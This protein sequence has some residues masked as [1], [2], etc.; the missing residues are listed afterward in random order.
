MYYDNYDDDT[1]D[2]D[3]NGDDGDATVVVVVAVG[4]VVAVVVVTSFP[5][6][7]VPYWSLNFFSNFISYHIKSTNTNIAN[8]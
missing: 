7:F 6:N 5:K 2:D 3:D 4:G 8:R 1:G